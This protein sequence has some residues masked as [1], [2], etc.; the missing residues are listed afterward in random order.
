MS[1]REKPKV[2][3]R[4]ETLVADAIRLVQLTQECVNGDGKPAG[5]VVDSVM[6][7]SALIAFAVHYNLGGGEVVD[8]A[9]LAAW[10]LK[11]NV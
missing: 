10:R 11:E 1:Q 3:E 7:R 6:L 4:A 9:R 5:P 2:G 8:M